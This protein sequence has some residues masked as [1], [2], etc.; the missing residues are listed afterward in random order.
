MIKARA[1]VN[2]R[3][4]FGTKSALQA[5]RNGVE[6]WGP[7]PVAETNHPGHARELAAHA[8]E[9]GIDVVLAVGGDGTANETA[10]ALVRTPVAL[11][12]LPFGSGNG[13][14]RT[15]GI[16]I[17]SVRRAVNALADGDVRS[18][19]VGF[20]EG[21]GLE[22]PLP[23][24][25]VAGAGLDAAIGAAFHEYGREGGRRGILSYFRLGF[26]VAW[27]YRSHAY[28]VSADRPLYEGRALFVTCANGPQFGGEAFI[29]PGALLDDGL[30][31]V[32]VLEDLSAAE[33]TR[34]AHR[35]FTRTLARSRRYHRYRVPSVDVRPHDGRLIFHRDGE[36]S[37]VDS[38]VRMYLEPRALRVV[39][40]RATLTSPASP[41]AGA[42]RA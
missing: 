40:P 33:V 4:G 8:V 11:G 26:P 1:V 34:N 12:L 36:P 19:D 42:A 35:M 21:P 13:L 16:P 25:N 7:V 20:V 5:L 29:A 9:D 31:D 15:L 14:A 30:L 10:Q 23:F 27:H 6:P 24:L 28:T 22:Q 39:V 2:P 32:V 41:F 3:A 18:I 37:E 17:R 38:A